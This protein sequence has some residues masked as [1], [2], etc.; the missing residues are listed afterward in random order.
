MGVMRPVADVGAAD[1]RAADVGAAQMRTA[2]GRRGNDRIRLRGRGGRRRMIG[3]DRGMVR[4]TVMA[5]MRREM[6]P[7]ADVGAADVGAAQMRTADGRRGQVG[8]GRRRRRVRVAY[9]RKT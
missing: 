7:V 5:M 3:M 1:V 4:R 8:V 9:R 2:D 6:P